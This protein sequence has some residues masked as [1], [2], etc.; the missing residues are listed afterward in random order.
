MVFEDDN[1][2][3]DSADD[4]S[5]NH[6]LNIEDNDEEEEADD[7]EELRYGYLPHQRPDLTRGIFLTVAFVVEMRLA[8]PE[9]YEQLKYRVMQIQSREKTFVEVEE[10]MGFNLRHHPEL[11]KKYN[12]DVSLVLPGNGVYCYTAPETKLRFVATFKLSDLGL[13][14]DDPEATF[15]TEC[16]LCLGPFDDNIRTLKCFHTFCNK[17]IMRQADRY[18]DAEYPSGIRFP[19]PTCRGEAIMETVVPYGEKKYNSILMKLQDKTV[20]Y[21]CAFAGTGCKETFM[22]NDILHH[23]ETSCR[24]R[25]YQCD[26]GCKEILFHHERHCDFLDCIDSLRTKWKTIA[27]QKEDIIRE[28][29]LTIINKNILISNLE[30]RVTALQARIV[31]MEERER[32]MQMQ[33]QEMQTGGGDESVDGKRKRGLGAAD[34]ATDA[35]AFPSIKRECHIV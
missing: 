11:L 18:A 25:K 10:L 32:R 27:N 23:M 5:I 19:C 7:R 24:F 1:F 2:S 34:A 28:Q 33:R 12:D 30:E 35:V 9:C 17:C 14:W 31:L 22:K 3:L 8:A 6:H 15:S 20:K 26:K 29:A 21:K 16:A 13:P 4:L